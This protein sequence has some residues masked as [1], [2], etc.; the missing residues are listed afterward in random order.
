[1][2]SYL[3]VKI[4]KAKPLNLGDYNKHRGWDIPVDEDPTREGYLVQY[5]DGYE[6][7]SPKEAFE[8]AYLPLENPTK[9]SQA[10]IEAFLLPAEDS[11]IDAKTTLVKMNTITGFVQ[12]E[13]SSCVDPANYDHALGVEIASKRIKDRIW[14]MLGF[15]L[16]WGRFGLKA[17]Q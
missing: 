8:A 10:E 4:L 11:Q 3:G 9:I 2:K 5:P 1:M 7:W 12:Y 6:S 14:P 16:Q 13:V 15:V 17:Q